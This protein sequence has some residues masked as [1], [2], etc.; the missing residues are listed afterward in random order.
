MNNNHESIWNSCLDVIKDNI[1]SVSFRTW[2]EPIVP[3]KVEN[4]VLTIQVPSQFFY[5]LLEEQYINILSKT[6]RKEM[7][8][9]AKLEYN[10]VMESNIFSNS[11][12]YIIRIPAKQDT[13]LKNIPVSVP[14]D[15]EENQIKNPFIIP[16]IKKFFVDPQLNPDK[17]FSNFIEGD[18][19]KLARS[20]GYAVSKNAGGTA[21]NPLLIYGGSG[22]GKTINFYL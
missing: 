17:T 1:T 16:G 9:D 5:E 8:Q 19:N 11:K 4:N 18:C 12:P 14:F 22:L 2:F 15:A 3:L 6:L 20:A 13:K 21:F 7:G 10:I